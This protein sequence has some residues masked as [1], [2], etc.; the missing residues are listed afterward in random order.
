MFKYHKDK[1]ELRELTWKNVDN[2]KNINNINDDFISYHW[3][4]RK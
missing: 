2:L 1:V 4:M 3:Y